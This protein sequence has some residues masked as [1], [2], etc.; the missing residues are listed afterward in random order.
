GRPRPFHP[1]VRPVAGREGDDRDGGLRP[2]GA[3][4]DRRSGRSRPEGDR[5]HART[6]RLISLEWAAM[7][8]QAGGWTRFFKNTGVVGE[9]VL[10]RVLSGLTSIFEG[11]SIEDTFKTARDALKRIFAC[12]E[13]SIFVHDPLV[14]PHM[15]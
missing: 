14:A 2:R 5:G 9:D 8:E 7:T 6:A 10:A 3:G 1:A 11:G 4:R 13:L 12:Q 15:D